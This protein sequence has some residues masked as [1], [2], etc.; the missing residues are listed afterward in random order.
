M[1]STAG[2]STHC[3]SGF[4]HSP[5]ELFGTVIA[6]HRSLLPQMAPTARE[7]DITW[8]VEAPAVALSSSGYTTA[9]DPEWF[10][11]YMVRVLDGI[12]RCVCIFHLLQQILEHLHI[13]VCSCLSV[14]C[15][16]DMRNGGNI[17][18]VDSIGGHFTCSSCHTAPGLGPNKIVFLVFQCCL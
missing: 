17:A 6:R 9:L 16:G 2:A 1:L 8:Y 3:I 13:H 14:L 11:S 4:P 5:S 10:G 7:M 15:W 18:L 12:C